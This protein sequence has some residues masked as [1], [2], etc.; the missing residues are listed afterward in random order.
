MAC[1][2][3]ALPEGALLSG[4]G[5]KEPWTAVEPVPWRVSVVTRILAM[6]PI[7]RG[8]WLLES[9]VANSG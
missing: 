5:C 1:V 7:W 2:I 4:Q 8:I 9:T 3:R 6:S